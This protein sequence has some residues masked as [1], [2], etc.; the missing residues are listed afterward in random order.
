[1]RVALVARAFGLR[2]WKLLS[3]WR[4]ATS[5]PVLVA[6]ALHLAAPAMAVPTSAA[7]GETPAVGPPPPDD[8]G[9]PG[10]D[11]IS[12]SDLKVNLLMIRAGN[13]P[14]A[15]TSTQASLP[16]LQATGSV[17]VPAS[18]GLAQPL[19]P[20]PASVGLAARWSLW[21]DLRGGLYQDDTGSTDISGT[22][23]QATAG[24]GYHLSDDTE[25]GLMLTA[26][27]VRESQDGTLNRMT[28]NGVAVGP[29]VNMTFAETLSFEARAQWGWSSQDIRQDVAGTLYQG[30]GETN[31]L[32]AE[33]RL[34][35]QHDLGGVLIVPDLTFFYGRDH[36]QSHTLS[37]GAS[38]LAVDADNESLGRASAG[39]NLS[40]AIDL[41]GGTLSPFIAGR[42]AWD[43]KQS[44][45]AAGAV[46]ATLSTGLSYATGATTASA[47]LEWD[48]I[49][50]E[51]LESAA[52][53]FSLL[54]A[55]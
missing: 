31:R 29:Y 51:G 19:L 12:A 55:F 6:A 8:G 21:S 28:G 2:A 17:A 5:L 33:A 36:H 46:R 47:T 41:E 54:H 34:S 13:A 9:T 27:S 44:D 4:M 49:R 32:L 25:V 43:F 40:R 39:L 42:V 3:A 38:T 53:K 16:S 20:P 26:E 50:S 18:G 7:G 37:A 35:T 11:P 52:V 23:A 22:F 24:M 48:G 14:T 1:M 30:N 45:P 10:Q 15:S